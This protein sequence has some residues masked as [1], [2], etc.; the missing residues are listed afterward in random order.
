MSA[1]RIPRRNVVFAVLLLGLCAAST[2]HATWPREA[3]MKQAYA[4]KVPMKLGAWSATKYKFDER[5]LELLGTD[6]VLARTYSR[7][8]QP[9]VDFVVVFAKH[10]RRATHPPEIC[11]KGEGW[12]T[13]NLMKR[14]A[15][16]TILPERLRGRK[17]VVRE[18]VVSKSGVKTLVY[19]FY[20]S[21]AKYTH[22]YWRQQLNALFGRLVD[23]DTSDALI[24][25]IT[26]VDPS[27]IEAARGRLDEF[28]ALALPEVDAHL[29]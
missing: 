16:P 26:R 18:L 19:Y 1:K 2:T 5:T 4:E 9:S 17:F 12:M 14:Q 20:K 15:G 28:L 22:S 13:E 6:D 8:D 23:P 7:P 21:G 10:T 27:G 29:P 25:L 24:R 3:P 11:L